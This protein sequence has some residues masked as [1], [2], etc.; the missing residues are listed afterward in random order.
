MG[1]LFSPGTPNVNVPAPPPVPPA[2][3]PATLANPEVAHAAASETA[4]AA[5]AAGG[6][7]SNTL[8]TSSQGSLGAPNLAKASLLGQ[9]AA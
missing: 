9:G 7:F 1:S 8:K 3:I 2:A 5:L 4:R 6:G